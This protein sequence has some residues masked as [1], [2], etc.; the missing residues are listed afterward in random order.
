MPPTI[1]RGLLALAGLGFAC[2][3]SVDLPQGTETATDPSVDTTTGPGPIDSASNDDTVPEPPATSST[4][5][6]ITT[7]SVDDTTTTSGDD[8]TGTPPDEPS[9]SRLLIFYTPHGYYREQGLGAMLEALSGTGMGVLVV[10]GIENVAIDPEGID[11]ADAHS[12]SSAGLLTGGL[13]GSGSNGDDTMFNPHFAGGPSLEVVLGELLSAEVPIASTHLGVRASADAP[14]P[15]GVS[16]WG[17][18]EPR[19]PIIDP[20]QGFDMLF[21]DHPGNDELD[22]LREFLAGLP[23][24]FPD[25]ALRAQLSLAAAAFRYDITRV[26]LVTLDVGI[27]ELQW[28]PGWPLHELML[29]ANPG[30]TVSVHHDCAD[31]LAL[32]TDELFT[33]VPGNDTTL[34]ESTAIVWLSDMGDIPPAHTQDSIL[35]IILDGSGTFTAGEVEVDADQADLATTLAMALGVDLGPFGHPDLDATPIPELLAR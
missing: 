29:D 33:P 16:Y 27:P 6:S 12:T 8:S 26:Q 19:A 25:L 35:T 22:E 18:D 13:L 30:G 15:L 14:I 17:A 32:F 2:G 9:L 5:T 20:V 34:L 1:H 7:G 31:L 10:H 11:V 24:G 3:P 23:P 4:T 21:A 28:I